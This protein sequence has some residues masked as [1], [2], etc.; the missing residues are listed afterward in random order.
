MQ[1]SLVHLLSLCK[2]EESDHVLCNEGI[3]AYSAEG[4][5]DFAR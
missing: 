4:T 1:Y 5:F 2:Y 3:S